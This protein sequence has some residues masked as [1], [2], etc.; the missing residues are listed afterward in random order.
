MSR[1][2]KNKMIGQEGQTQTYIGYVSWENDTFPKGEMIFPVG[3]FSN[4]EDPT[5][6]TVTLT[7]AK[8]YT[9]EVPLAAG[10]IGLP[11]L[12]SMWT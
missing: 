4:N 5:V 11:R 9:R 12:E 10:R 8:R 1:S 7:K 2:T 3:N 6:P